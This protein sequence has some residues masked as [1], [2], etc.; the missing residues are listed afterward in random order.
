MMHYLLGL[1]MIMS[2]GYACGPSGEQPAEAP[3]SP[4]ERV[5]EDA[6]KDERSVRIERVVKV[7]D[8]F[9]FMDSLVEDYGARL[10]YAIDEYVLARHNPWLIDRLAHTDYYYLKE[11]GV[12]NYNQREIDILLPGD[13]LRVPSRA[14]AANI[15]DTL[16]QTVLDLNIPEFRLRVFIYGEERHAFPV[17]VGRNRRRYLAMAERKVDL[18]TRVGLGKIVRVNRDPAYINPANNHRYRVTRRDDGR[19]TRLPRIPFL[20]PEIN[21]IRYG[22]LIHPTTNPETLGKA[23]SNGCI[24][25]AEADQWRIYYHAPVGTA[26][27]VRYD[28]KVA[29]PDGDTIR[30][31]DIYPGIRKESPLKTAALLPFMDTGDCCSACLPGNRVPQSIH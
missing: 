27:V 30:L 3:P 15:R 29:G 4:A 1:L 8:Y 25:T 28:L 23:Y 10:P 7:K 24:G 9:S 21:G 13:S 12:F 26:I 5:E 31:P 19:L 14:E 16:A 18:R 6:P 17:R 11:R 22:Q 2:L 20:E